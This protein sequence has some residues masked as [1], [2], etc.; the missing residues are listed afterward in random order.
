[1]PHARRERKTAPMQVCAHVRWWVAAA[2]ALAFSVTSAGAAESEALESA[3]Q[4][5]RAV[6]ARHHLISL[7]T[8]EPLDRGKSTEFRYDRYPEVERIQL[9]ETT[10]ARR[11]GTSWMKSNDWAGTGTKVRR[12]KAEELDAL[13]SFV[14]APLNN[15]SLSKDASQGGTVVHLLRREARENN[16]RIFYELRREHSTGMMYP[17]FVFDKT[18]SEPDGDALLVGFAGLMYSGDEKVKVNINYSYMFLVDVQPAE[19]SGSPRKVP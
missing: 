16:E 10:Y 15:T 7:V 12:E 13:V 2:L 3:L 11:K 18:K 19:A 4:N 14:D 1:M 9:K 17:Q 6:V 8:I 5:S